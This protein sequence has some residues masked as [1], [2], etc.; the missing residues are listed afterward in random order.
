MLSIAK[1]FLASSGM[2][3]R[4]LEIMHNA[5][6]DVIYFFLIYFD[7]WIIVP[8]ALIIN[9][10]SGDKILVIVICIWGSLLYTLQRNSISMDALIY[11]LGVFVTYLF[12]NFVIYIFFKLWKILI[13]NLFKWQ[14]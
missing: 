10:L 7:F 8:S 6:G 3:G 2:E 13:R 1:I 4:F 14:K 9:A 11:A 5:F 12:F